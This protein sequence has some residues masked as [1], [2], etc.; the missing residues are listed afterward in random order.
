MFHS[1]NGLF[2]WR[3]KDGGDVRIIKTS[4][5]K[6]PFTHPIGDGQMENNVVCDVVLAENEWASVV[7]AVSADGENYERWMSAR[8]F[9]G[10]PLAEQS[11]WK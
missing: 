4:D 7:A 9:H 8:I 1:K 5:G 3:Q 6:D 10:L 11:K 2:F